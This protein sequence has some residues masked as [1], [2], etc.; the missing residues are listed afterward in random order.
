MLSI[1]VY[2]LLHRCTLCPVSSS[3]SFI[4]CVKSIRILNFWVSTSVY[5]S[6][7]SEMECCKLWSGTQ[8][9]T[10]GVGGGRAMGR[11]LLARMHQ[12]QAKALAARR[13]LVRATQQALS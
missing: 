4:V 2:L 12:P 6:S 5:A 1:E 9:S 8:R 3:L 13:L 7:M 10:M 11:L